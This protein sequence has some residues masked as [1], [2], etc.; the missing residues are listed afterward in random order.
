MVKICNVNLILSYPIIIYLPILKPVNLGSIYFNNSFSF[1]ISLTFKINM[2]LSYF[3]KK[4]QKDSNK[5]FPSPFFNKLRN[6]L[7]RFNP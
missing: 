4:N 7:L 5:I 6:N 1:V 3:I 2:H